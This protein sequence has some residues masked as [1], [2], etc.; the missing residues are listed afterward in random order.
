MKINTRVRYLFTEVVKNILESSVE[1]NLV[2]IKN[3][4]FSYRAPLY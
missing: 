4:E 3:G 2:T 1:G